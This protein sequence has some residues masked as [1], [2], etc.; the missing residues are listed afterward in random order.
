M[1]LTVQKEVKNNVQNTKKTL[2][3]AKCAKKNPKSAIYRSFC[4]IW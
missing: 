4:R 1:V 2:K 3:S